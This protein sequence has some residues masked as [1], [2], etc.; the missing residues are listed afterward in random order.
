MRRSKA[1]RIIAASLTAGALLTACSGSGGGSTDS[2]SQGGFQLTKISVLDGSIWEINRQ[3]EF[4]FNQ[5]VN[6]ATVS[7][8]TINIQTNTGMPATGAFFLKGVDADGDGVNETTNPRVVIFQPTCPTRSDLL[9]AGLQPGSIPYTIVAPGLTSGA[10]NTVRSVS[11]AQLRDAQTRHFVTPASNDAGGAFIDTVSGPPVP[12]VR[13]IGSLEENASHIEYGMVGEKVYFE[14]DEVTQTYGLSDPGFEVPLNLFSDPTT[15]VAV[16]LYFNQPVSPDAGNI[17][18]SLLGL[19]FLDSSFEWTP[20]DTRVELVANCTQTGALVRLEPV[21]ILPVASSFR[22]V[23]RPGF[24]D[25]TGDTNLL[26][27]DNFGVAPT[28][29]VDFGSLTPSDDQSDEVL[30]EFMY[31]GGGIDSFEDRDTLTESPRAE[32]ADGKLTMAFNFTGTGGPAGTFDW[33]IKNGEVFFFDTTATSIVGG[34]GGIPTSTQNTVNGF[35]DVRNLI[36]EAGGTLRVQG[37]NIMTVNATGS[38]EIRGVLDVSGFN[39]KNV[40]TL[41]TGNQPEI[42][43]A[44]AAGGG[45]G[46]TASWVTNNSTPFGGRG[47]G[48]FGLPNGGGQGGESGYTPDSNKHKRRPGGGGAGRFGQDQAYD[49]NVPSGTMIVAEPGFVG[50]TTTTGGKGALT[51]EIPAQGGFPGPGPFLDDDDDNNFYGVHPVSV[52]PNWEYVLGEAQA[53]TAGS[54]GGGG[55]DACPSDKFPND[56]PPS[57]PWVIASDEKGGGG[58][59]GAGGINIRALGPIVFGATGNLHCDGGTGATGENVLYLDHIGGSGGSGSGGH[60]VLET[61]SYIDFTDG[62]ATVTTREWVTAVGGARVVGNT[63]YDDNAQPSASNGGAGGPGVIQFHVPNPLADPTPWGGGGDIFVPATVTLE[64]SPLHWVARPGPVVMVPLFGARSVAQSKWISLGG[65]DQNP[66]A[67]EGL[68]QFLFAGT[69][70]LDE[71]QITT[72]DGVVDELPSLLSEVVTG[73]STVT[74]LGDAVSM[75]IAGASLDPLRND[76]SPLSSDIYLRTPALLKNFVLRLTSTLTGSKDFNV[77]AASYVDDDAMPIL[78][79]TVDGSGGS[80]AAFVAQGGTVSYELIPRFF[81][82]AT[83]G[84]WDA[85][86]DTAKVIIAFSA[87]TADQFGNP[88]E[89]NPLLTDETDISQFNALLPGEIQFFRFK[90]I[91]EVDTVDVDTELIDMDFLRIPFRF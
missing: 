2:S 66:G 81:R 26:E 40:A 41:D 47:W 38:V 91:F 90:I 70:A 17:T 35:V 23:V 46:G 60:V 80:L 42:G 59:G 83:G 21:G 39:A 37:P 77:V 51:N 78:T 88:D 18:Q 31:S 56:H 22:V 62:G 57:N 10:V 11:G 13:A 64:D 86:P 72:T 74:V 12:V 52:P 45:K 82:V 85:L 30:E 36:V 65:A 7:L 6:F 20:I 44:G 49:G 43:G 25:L 16:M 14:H 67:A 8:N 27:I 75:S 50:N 71:G 34:P 33:V 69:D 54:G 58:G 5:D 4:T 79:V 55:G 63:Q 9:D 48:A 61:A 32:W 84:V 73:S 68:V 29:T 19:E 15:E 3:M 24:E 28:T 89:S 1:T 53:I 87:T 76:I